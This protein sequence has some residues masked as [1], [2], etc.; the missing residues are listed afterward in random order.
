MAEVD[1][2]EEPAWD[3]V[4]RLRLALDHADGRAAVGPV[5]DLAA[6]HDQLGRA[7]QR[8][9]AAFHRRRAGVAFHARPVDLVPALAL[10][11]GHHADRLLLALEDRALLDMRLEE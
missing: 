8:V 5:A 3:R 9:A 7:D 4:A 11:A 1:G 6:L 2:H 10:R